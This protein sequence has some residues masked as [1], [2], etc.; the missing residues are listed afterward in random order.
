VTER[1]TDE[2]LSELDIIRGNEYGTILH[3]ME[4][5]LPRNDNPSEFDAL[6]TLLRTE[7][8]EPRSNG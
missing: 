2:L 3:L 4:R 5:L 7:V 8:L 1:T 6:L